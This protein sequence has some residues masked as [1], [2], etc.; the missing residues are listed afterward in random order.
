MGH[1]RDSL[2]EREAIAKLPFYLRFE[3]DGCGCCVVH[4]Q[5]EGK[6]GSKETSQETT[7]VTEVR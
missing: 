7:A 5:K 1:C 3:Q 2:S 6:V 4:R